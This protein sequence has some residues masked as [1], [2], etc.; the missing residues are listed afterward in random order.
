MLWVVL[1]TNDPIGRSGT[2]DAVD[3]GSLFRVS[4]TFS[5]CGSNLNFGPKQNHFMTIT[6]KHS[7]CLRAEL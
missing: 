4:R 7:S 6:Q 2:N 3:F 5:N 1:P